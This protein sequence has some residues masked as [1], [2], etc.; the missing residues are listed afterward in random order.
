MKALPARAL[1]CFCLVL[2]ACHKKASD[3]ID[4]GTVTEG[5]YRNAFFGLE[6]PLPKDWSVQD[7]QTRQE[8]AEAGTKLIAGDQGKALMRAADQQTVNLLAVFEHPYGSPV[9][10]NPNITGV[11]ERVRN[12]PGIRR[13]Q[14]YLFHARK[15]LA[16]G[17]LKVEFPGDITT[18][19]LGGTDFDVLEVKTDLQGMEVRQKMHATLI[20]GYVLLLISSFATPEQEATLQG[21]L[22]GARLAAKH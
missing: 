11:A 1:L 16:G 3:E 5:V 18:V 4:Y 19:K 21:I 7:Q 6:L 15:L 13:G 14:D 12:S 17:Q 8:M 22:Q 20:K 2:A 9:P 10:F